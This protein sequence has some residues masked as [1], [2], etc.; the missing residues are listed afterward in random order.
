M[1]YTSVKGKVTYHRMDLNAYNIT[2]KIRTVETLK[3]IKSGGHNATYT[4]FSMFGEALPEY[5]PTSLLTKKQIEANKKG[6]PYSEGRSTYK[7]YNNRYKWK[8]RLKNE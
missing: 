6:G 5:P 4:R 1:G 3:T 7:S 8:G 2:N